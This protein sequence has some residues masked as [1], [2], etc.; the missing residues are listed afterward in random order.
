MQIILLLEVLDHGTTM[1]A[2]NYCTTGT[3]M[4]DTIWMKH[5]DLN[6][7]NMVLLQSKP[8]SYSSCYSVTPGTSHKPD[9]ASNKPLLLITD[10]LL[11]R[12]PLL[13]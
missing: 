8:A 9:F 5:P 2:D 1:N 6:T 11:Q 12:K 7:E 4:K 3:H 13:K 10:A